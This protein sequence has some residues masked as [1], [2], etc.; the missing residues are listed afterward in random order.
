[1]M[2]IKPAKER[3]EDEGALVALMSDWLEAR[4]EKSDKCTQLFDKM[5]PFFHKVL[6]EPEAAD[7]TTEAS[8]LSRIWADRDMFPKLSQW[9][10]GGD[11]WGES[12]PLSVFE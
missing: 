6:P 8:L 1:M 7:H 3:C 9:I 4:D 12:I 10:V 11:G 5:K 2:E